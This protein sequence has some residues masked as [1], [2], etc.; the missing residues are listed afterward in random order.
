MSQIPER[1]R[2]KASTVL[3][4]SY[5]LLH[6]GSSTSPPNDTSTLSPI[7]Y[8]LFS[9]CNGQPSITQTTFTTFHS[10]YLS[11]FSLVYLSP[12]F[13]SPLLDKSFFFNLSPSIL[14]TC[15]KNLFIVKYFYS[16][17]IF[18][19]LFKSQRDLKIPV[20]WCSY[21]TSSVCQSL[22]K[23]SISGKEKLSPQ[24]KMYYLIL[25][26]LKF[27]TKKKFGN[28]LLR[29]FTLKKTLL[30]KTVHYLKVNYPREF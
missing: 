17:N 1:S 11:T 24:K 2:S 28:L 20:T 6:L 21:L 23:I 27:V 14:S 5:N 12:C 26:K 13:L 4:V 29:L 19:Y 7:F 25:Y 16:N 15:L 8:A 18:I 30:L 9:F 22:K 10:I 3:T